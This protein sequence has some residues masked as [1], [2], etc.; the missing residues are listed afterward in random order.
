MNF[1]GLIQKFNADVFNKYSVDSGKML[2]HMGALGWVFSSLAQIGVVATDKNISKKDK[3]F[4]VPQEICDGVKNV[5]LYY[6]VS[7][8]I[9]RSGDF[10]VNKGFLITD[11]AEK[12]INALKNESVPT[13]TAVKG[14]SESILNYLSADERYHKQVKKDY[15][16]RNL[17]LILDKYYLLDSYKMPSFQN[18]AKVEKFAVGVKE[19]ISGFKG[20][21]GVVTSIV[22]SI[23]A[24]NL[25]TPVARNKM[26]GLYQQKFLMKHD[27]AQKAKNYAP[28]PLPAAFKNFN[29]SSGLKI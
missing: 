14:L 18:Q 11:E 8:A 19:K 9:K 28:Q 1:R 10:L 4:L 7:Q 24:S 3:K 15:K 16:G 25:L 23:I 13:R 2:I 26:A 6:T 17:D 29:V 21:L 22:A 5:G 12:V 20:G 27:E